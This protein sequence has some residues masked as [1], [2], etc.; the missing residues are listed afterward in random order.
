MAQLQEAY[1]LLLTTV[2]AKGPFEQA[3]QGTAGV[4]L[5]QPKPTPPSW[6]K[7]RTTPGGSE[8]VVGSLLASVVNKVVA[9]FDEI[10]M[11]CVLFL[12]LAPHQA[13]GI[14]HLGMQFTMGCSMRRPD[15]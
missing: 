5:T 14:M 1:F 15:I 4:G 2:D 11:S 6:Y 7:E 12:W 10:Q 9:N 8:I 13:A 3:N